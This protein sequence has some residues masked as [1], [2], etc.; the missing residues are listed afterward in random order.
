[1]R[2]QT[3]PVL[4]SAIAATIPAVL[5]ESYVVVVVALVVGVVVGGWLRAHV[6]TVKRGLF[7]LVAWALTVAG[8]VA[9]SPRTV[10]GRIVDTATQA[11]IDTASV[12]L[13]SGQSTASD[14]GGGFS[15]LVTASARLLTVVAPGYRNKTLALADAAATGEWRIEL[16]A[17]DS[18]EV[19]TIEGVAPDQTKPTSYQLTGEDI[20]RLPGAGNDVLRA[21]QSLPGVAR[22]PYN[23]GGLVLRGQS[24]R[25]TSVFLDGIEV[26]LAFH[27]GGLTSF[28]PAAILDTVTI[29]NGGFDVAWGRTQGGVITLATREARSDGWRAG[30]DVGL[31]H[32]GALAEGPLPRGGSVMIG[33]RRS[34]LDALVSP[35]VAADTPLPSYLDAQVRA[36]WGQPQRAGRIVAQSFVSVDRVASSEVSLTSAFVR[37]GVTYRKSWGPTHL[38]VVPWGGWNGLTL[39]SDATFNADGS[40]GE[41]AAEFRRPT[42]LMGVRADLLRDTCWGHVRGGLDAQGGHLGQ[43]EI[44][45]DDIDERVASSLWWGDV[46]GSL[47]VNWQSAQGRLAIKPGLRVESYGA[48]GEIVIDPRLNL[49]QRL[50]EQLVLRQAIG[51]FH[52]QPTPMELEGTLGNPRLRSAY[53]DQLSLGLEAELPAGLEASI[54]GYW[55]YGRRQPTAA[56]RPGPDPAIPEPNTGG[57]GPIFTELLEEQ[58]GSF[59]YREAVGRSRSRGIELSLRRRTER[60]FGFLG[61]TIAAAERTDDPVRFVGWRPYQLDQTHHFTA[62]GSVGFRH[63]RVGGR[64][65]VVSGN[66]YSPASGAD[67]FGNPI[68]DVYGGRLPVFA[69]IDVRADRVW[70]RPWGEIVFY[71]DLQ[72]ASNRRNI[73]GRDVDD[74]G[75]EKDIRGLPTLPFIGLEFV[76]RP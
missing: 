38:E 17:D 14:V 49:R 44:N 31:L 62:V 27:F 65:S 67:E 2:C 41:L 24:P 55:H 75:V 66:P 8:P 72:N 22:I 68:I 59:D 71:I 52:Q 45:T 16:E 73:E 35:F 26:P 23:F 21:V 4:R 64:I 33:V 50:G 25:D 74:N 34:Y 42:Y 1:V 57:L 69:A 5:L 60:W 10:S 28:Y 6:A 37:S 11:P 9:A 32:S 18:S 53:T 40:E 46:A 47:E 15:L 48:T 70:R 13:D 20:R 43:I 3:L 51:R 63:W 61:Y 54:T 30:G 7:T 12:L 58:F 29:T 39:A 76:P 56:I 19:I 36:S